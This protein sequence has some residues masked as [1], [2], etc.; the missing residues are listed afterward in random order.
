[1]SGPAPVPAHLKLQDLQS[2]VPAKSKGVQNPLLPHGTPHPLP[3][4]RGAVE[5]NPVIAMAFAS[6]WYK[7]VNKSDRAWAG[8]GRECVFAWPFWA[9]GQDVVR[10]LVGKR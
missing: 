5:S 6:W 2:S 1:M 10:G 7:T 4:L 8:P 3:V 9:C